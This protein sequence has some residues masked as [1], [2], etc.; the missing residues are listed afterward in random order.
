MATKATVLV[1]D[2]EPDV[3]GFVGRVLQRDGYEVLEAADGVEALALLQQ[4]AGH[5]R[6]VVTDIRMPRM[7]GLTLG[8][9]VNAAYPNVRVLY[10]SA[11]TTE[12]APPKKPRSRFLAKPFGPD[13]LLKTIQNLA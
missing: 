13:V 7:D 9:K 11:F 3:R 1:V 12:T 5:V 6:I 2:D 10:I 8:R 4:Q